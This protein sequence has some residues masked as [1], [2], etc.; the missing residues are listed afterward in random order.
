[1]VNWTDVAHDDLPA[2]HVREITL[3]R[4]HNAKLAAELYEVKILLAAAHGFIWRALGLVE[5]PGPVDET[6]RDNLFPGTEFWGGT[7][8]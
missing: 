6:E 5:P 2:A 4:E 8:Q 1:M 7:E 3:L